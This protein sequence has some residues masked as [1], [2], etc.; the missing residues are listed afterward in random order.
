[1]NSPNLRNNQWQSHHHSSPRI[2]EDII[3]D[4]QITLDWVDTTTFVWFSFSCREPH[5]L[6]L[7]L[8]CLSKV[9]LL[10]PYED[11]IYLQTPAYPFR[12]LC[13]LFGIG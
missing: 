7:G 3:D 5:A 13:A 12:S 11:Q 8:K 1:M 9:M 2:V 6:L 10:G 4:L